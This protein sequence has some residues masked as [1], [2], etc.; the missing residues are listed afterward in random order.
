MASG[1]LWKGSSSFTS[2]PGGRT[3]TKLLHLRHLLLS[4]LLHL[5]HLLLSPLL[6]P[7]HLVLFSLGHW[8]LVRL[9][10][11]KVLMLLSPLL[12][13]RHLL[14]SPLL[15]LPHLV[16][17]SLGHCRLVISSLPWFPQFGK[18]RSS[19]KQSSRNSK[20]RWRPAARFSALPLTHARPWAWRTSWRVTCH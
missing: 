19:C 14:L 5:R 13:L 17:V 8:S 16:L 18:A 6:H 11:L 2:Q 1:T 7:P 4:P 9:M 10:L 15:H 20:Q 3:G 12:H